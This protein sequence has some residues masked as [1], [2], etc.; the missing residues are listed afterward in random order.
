L[1]PGHIFNGILNSSL[2]P[3]VN[4]QSRAAAVVGSVADNTPPHVPIAGPF[5][6]PPHNKGTI[7]TG[8][9]TVFING[10]AA[11]RNGDKA[12]TCNDPVDVPIGTVVA[13]S[14]VFIG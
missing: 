1:I 2:S 9:A 13:V 12:K 11:A 4:V 10:K 6:R 14:T 5:Q 3:D 8:S 7:V